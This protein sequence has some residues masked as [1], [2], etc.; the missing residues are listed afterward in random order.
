LEVEE[1]RQRDGP[2]NTW[3]EVVDKDLDDWTEEQAMLWIVTNG[4]K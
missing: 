3:K 4:G 1:A 2:R